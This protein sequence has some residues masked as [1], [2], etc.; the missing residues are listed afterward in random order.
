MLI[1]WYWFCDGGEKML[2]L[3]LLLLVFFVVRFCK[4]RLLS[5]L[6][7]ALFRNLFLDRSPLKFQR[8][9][10][11]AEN[12]EQGENEWDER[13]QFCWSAEVWSSRCDKPFDNRK[14]LLVV[15][16]LLF[17]FRYCCCSCLFAEQFKLLV[18]W[19]WILC[20]RCKDQGPRVTFLEVFCSLL[21]VFACKPECWRGSGA[22]SHRLH[23][24]FAV[25][26]FAV[27]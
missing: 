22:S 2:F 26:R 12:L 7:I 16:W 14:L 3:L 4:I 21:C 11:Y 8:E 15:A 19:N 5:V 20:E 13:G 6:L 10:S 18:Y 1:Y 17:C 24:V 25:S 9:Y 27:I 23:F